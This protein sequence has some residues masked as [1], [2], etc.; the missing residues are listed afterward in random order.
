MNKNLL[1]P[2]LILPFLFLLPSCWEEDPD[3]EPDPVEEPAAATVTLT[4]SGTLELPAEGGSA[5]V[6]VKVS[7]SYYKWSKSKVDWMTIASD[8]TETKYNKLVVTA[9]PNATGATRSTSITVWASIDGDSKDA[10]ATL[11]IVQKSTDT[12]ATEPNAISVSCSIDFGS[13]SVSAKG[14]E[15]LTL[16]GTTILDGNNPGSVQVLS[17][18]HTPCLTLLCGKDGEVLMMARDIYSD[19]GK[20]ELNA[21]STALAYVTAHPLFA[22]VKGVMPFG[23][24]KSMILGSPLYSAFESQIAKAIKAGKPIFDSSNKALIGALEDLMNNL[25]VDASAKPAT[26]ATSVEGLTGVGHLNVWVEGKTLKVQNPGIAPMYEGFVYDSDGN[27]VGRL[28]VPAGNDYGITDIVFRRDI[29]GNEV[30][31]F[32]LAGC[33]GQY[34]FFFTRDTQNARMDFAVRWFCS[35]LDILGAGL[36]TAEMQSLRGA[37]LQF[38]AVRAAALEQMLFSG[39]YTYGELI[40]FTYNFIQD[41]LASPYFLEL[42]QGAAA[43]ALQASAAKL[44]KVVT[45]YCALRGST[46]VIARYYSMIDSPHTVEF[47]LCS[48]GS[49][50]LFPCGYVKLE[51]I[52]GDRQ[53]DVSRKWLD[54]PIKVKVDPGNND[55]APNYFIVRFTVHSGEG[56]VAMS[57]VYT[58]YKLEAKTYWMLGQECFMQI[59]KV[60]V[61]DPAT[62]GVISEEPLYVTAFATDV[63]DDDPQN[64]IPES[65]QGEWVE[66]LSSADKAAG[67][68]PIEIKLTKNTASYYDPNKPDL[69]FNGFSVWYEEDVSWHGGHWGGCIFFTDEEDMEGGLKNARFLM[70]VSEYSG[71]MDVGLLYGYKE[72]EPGCS[73]TFIPKDWDDHWIIDSWEGVSWKDSA[74][75]RVDNIYIN[76]YYL[77]DYHAPDQPILASL[78]DYHE[79]IP[80]FQDVEVRIVR[81]S[82]TSADL[83]FVEDG[84]LFMKDVHYVPMGYTDHDWQVGDGDLITISN[85]M[86]VYSGLKMW[87]S[88]IPD[89]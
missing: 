5:E 85:L 73:A 89:F 39:T 69:T 32:S 62:G 57:E 86:N 36:S 52:S 54:E 30:A 78:Y 51:L 67:K 1:K 53:A 56:V 19:G 18:N 15:L 2:L 87:N 42:C 17:D 71:F 74:S 41:F 7:T 66:A 22:P 21:R 77:S 9:Q 23:E 27:E 65:L 8:K 63:E 10:E 82:D 48:S 72:N 44:S 13:S 20:L 59:L 43:K 12:G 35:S 60:E 40:E 70:G 79:K 16:T 3:P 76:I 49:L 24:L 25:C 38:I 33:E 58:D 14:C 29:T 26:K 46:N 37:V 83:Y 31:G 47:C 34:N 45:I 88:F 64:T 11:K 84:A 6:R 4:P 28:D 50:P 68:K 75:G 81:T 80:S 55:N 61:L